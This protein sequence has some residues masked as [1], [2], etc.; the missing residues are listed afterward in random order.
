MSGQRSRQSSPCAT[1]TATS[2][3][4]TRHCS[5][6]LGGRAAVP[7]SSPSADREPV[8]PRSPRREHREDCEAIR[9]VDIYNP[10]SVD[11]SRCAAAEAGARAAPEL[12]LWSSHLPLQL[13]PPLRSRPIGG[14][15]LGD[16]AG[17][18]F[19]AGWLGVAFSPSSLRLLELWPIAPP[20]C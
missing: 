9:L 2:T 8:P 1:A 20:K 13:Q 12:L 18:A 4:A 14:L 10:G 17:S 5:F 6:D 19:G 3:S 7:R 15:T 11:Q 16:V